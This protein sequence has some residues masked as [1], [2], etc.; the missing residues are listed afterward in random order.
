VD[1]DVVAAAFAYKK[2]RRGVAVVAA[3]LLVFVGASAVGQMTQDRIGMI[4]A[5]LVVIGFVLFMWKDWRCPACGKR[6]GPEFGG[7]ECPHCST[8]L[9]A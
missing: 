3:L 6:L 2:R 4:F 7:G 8:R 5:L 1:K 9:S